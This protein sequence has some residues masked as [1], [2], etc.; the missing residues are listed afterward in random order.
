MFDVLITMPRHFIISGDMNCLGDKPDA[1]YQRLVTLLSFYNIT[2]VN[3]GPTRINPATGKWSTLDV[4][5][6][7]ESGCRLGSPATTDIG[8]SDHSLIIAQLR[9][10]RPPAHKVTCTFHVFR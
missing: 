6:E 7:L 9:C 5:M 2:M 4:I 3:C 1:F 8:F 10:R